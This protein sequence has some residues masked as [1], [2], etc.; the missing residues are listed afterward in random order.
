MTVGERIV[1]LRKERNINQSEL[2]KMMDVS[3]QAVSKWENDLT[4][5][6]TLRLI[7]LA[8]ALNTDV[9]YLATGKKAELKTKKEVIIQEK[10]IEVVVEKI[11]EK[12]VIIEKTIEVP[13]IMERVIETPVYK[14]VIRKECVR[15]PLEYVILAL[16]SFVFVSFFIIFASNDIE[17]HCYLMQR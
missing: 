6:D 8:D 4:A 16:V 3:R 17:L 5:P 12:P 15:Y 7:Q 14:G 11:V 9:E 10:P 2:A 1:R 13:T